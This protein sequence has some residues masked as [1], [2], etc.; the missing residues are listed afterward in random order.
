MDL[1]L[2]RFNSTPLEYFSAEQMR[3]IHGA[4][5]EI[6]EDCGTVVHH[7]K[8]VE[9][10]QKAGA[11][12][13]DDKR[14]FIPSGLAEWA[15]RSAPSRVTIYDRKGKPSMFLEGR[16]VYYGTGS[17]CPHL[18][19]SFTGERRDFRLKDVEDA[20]RLVDFLPNID[21][22][23]SMGLAPDVPTDLQYQYK[24]ATMIRNSIKPQVIT[25][26]DR[27]SLEDITDIAAAAAGGREELRRKPIFVLYDE[28]TSPLIHMHEAM[29]KLLF[30]AEN[31][32]PTNYSPGIMAGGTGPVTMAGAITQADAEILAGL[33]IHQLARPGAPFIFGAGMSPMDMHSMQPTYSSPEAMMEQAGLCQIGRC[34]YDLPTW[35]FGGCSASKLADEQAVNEASTYIM[36]S[37]WM[38]TNLVHDVGYLEFGLTYSFDLLVM[39][40]EFIGQVRRMMEGIRVDPEYL[41]VDA[42][43]RVGPGGHFLDDP[44]TLGHFRENWQPGITDRRTYETWKAK[45]ASTMGQRTRAKIKAILD[46]HQPEPLSPETDAQI[47]EILRRAQA[48]IK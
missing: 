4:A 20:V 22:T 14:V 37:G 46:K 10:L 41:A 45:G 25:A 6:L 36:M 32:L 47:E 27:K 5:L 13:K 7:K 33:V 39:C 23:M 2:K 9:L 35:G 42:V 30:M 38:G 24:Y 19:D 43:K 26:A 29:E 8:C 40:D 48:R 34:L 12:V 3:D 15:I 11:Y 44:H 18:L 17:D 28:P 31:R 1:S 16:N 21:F